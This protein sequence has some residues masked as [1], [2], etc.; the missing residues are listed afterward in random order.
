MVVKG[1][2]RF[3]LV[4][5]LARSNNERRAVQKFNLLKSRAFSPRGAPMKN[6]NLEIVLPWE[7]ESEPPDL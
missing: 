5:V 4:G 6:F 2:L 7:S 1:N 3:Y